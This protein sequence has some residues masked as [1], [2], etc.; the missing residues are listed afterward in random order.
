[1]ERIEIKVNSNLMNYRLFFDN[2]VNILRGDSATG[3][4]FLL[5]LLDNKRNSK[6]D[7]Q[8]TYKLN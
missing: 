6:I 4:S 8:S 2:R 3:K 1:M 5:R 7:I